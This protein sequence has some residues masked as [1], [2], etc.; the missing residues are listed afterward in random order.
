MENLELIFPEIF[1]SF[2]LMSV[3]LIGVSKKWL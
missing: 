1:L 2:S 3:L